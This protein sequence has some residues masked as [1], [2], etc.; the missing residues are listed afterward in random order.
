MLRS[1]TPLNLVHYTSSAH[2]FMRQEL[3]TRNGQ[4]TTKNPKTMTIILT[5]AM[6]T[7]LISTTNNYNLA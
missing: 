3:V 4:T 7:H 6:T 1:I 2:N 5:I